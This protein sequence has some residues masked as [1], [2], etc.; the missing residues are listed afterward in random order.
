[1]ASVWNDGYRSCYIKHG[2]SEWY[3]YTAMT[4]DEMSLVV[5]VPDNLI[6]KYKKYKDKI[7]EL[8]KSKSKQK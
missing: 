7:I 4:Y 6:S 5:T 3:I 8:L 2:A 1:M